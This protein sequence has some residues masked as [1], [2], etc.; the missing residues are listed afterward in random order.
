[1][2]VCFSQQT[3]AFLAKT[4]QRMGTPAINAGASHSRRMP[5]PQAISFWRVLARWRTILREFSA[6]FP[7]IFD[8]SK[9]TPLK[10]TC[11]T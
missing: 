6:V 2:Q 4:W 1:V 9:M 10:D 7:I 8:L 11:L 3:P 5:V